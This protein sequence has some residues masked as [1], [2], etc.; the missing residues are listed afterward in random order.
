[1][2][3][4]VTPPST[5]MLSVG[6][7]ARSAR[8]WKKTFF[9]TVKR[10]QIHSKCKACGHAFVIDN[11]HKLST[12]IVK[13]PPKLETDVVGATKSK[14]NGAAV[15]DEVEELNGAD[16]SSDGDDLEDD[17]D[18][19]DPIDET[20][21]LTAGIGKLVIDKD[22]EKSVGDRLDIFEKFLIKAKEEDNIGDGKA[23]V[24]EAERLDVKQKAALVMAVAALFLQ[25]WMI[26][27]DTPAKA[28]ASDACTLTPEKNP[29]KLLRLMRSKP[30]FRCHPVCCRG[31]AMI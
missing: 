25:Q 7:A 9:Q 3:A 11:K 28:A 8:T 17:G 23:L 4:G 1:M 6:W 20:G 10:N 30:M 26:E 21:Q 18:W 29:L 5:W 2:F 27:D 19:A 14:E 15:K 22:L 16:K 13:N 24:D 12:F 31:A